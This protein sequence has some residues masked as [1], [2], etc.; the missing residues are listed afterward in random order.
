MVTSKQQC[1]KSNKDTKAKQHQQRNTAAEMKK[2][3][4]Y[5]D[6]FFFIRRLEPI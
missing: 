3:K 2:G 5:R 4:A 1:L 6:F